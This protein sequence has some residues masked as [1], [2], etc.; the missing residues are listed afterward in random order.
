MDWIIVIL[1]GALAG[2]LASLVMRTDA[3]QGALANIII[4]IIG[5]ALARWLFGGVLGLGGSAA[6]SLTIMGVVWAVV[7]AIILIFI[8]RSLRVLR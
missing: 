4:G 5:A 6:G 7:G 3:Q 2:W 8:L 1:V